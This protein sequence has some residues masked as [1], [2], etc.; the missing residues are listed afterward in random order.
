[1]KIG[2]INR[3]GDYPPTTNTSVHAYQITNRL[4]EKGCKIH[5]LEAYPH[6]EFKRFN[7]CE[8]L[9]FLSS[10]DILYIKMTGRLFWDSLSLLKLFKPSKLPLV[11]EMHSPAEFMGKSR[12]F[13][14]GEKRWQLLSK[15][16]DAA[17]CVSKEVSNYAKN[18]GLKDAYVVQNGSDPEMFS[19]EKRDPKIYSFLNHEDLKILWTGSLGY[20]WHGSDII[21]KVAKRFL[22]IN[23]RVK[24]ILIGKT[25]DANLPHEKNVIILNQIPYFSIPP[26]IASA[27]ICLCLYNSFDNQCSIGF[28]FSPL[29]LFDYMASAK[30]VIASAMGQIKEVIRD[31]ENGFITNNSV[32]DIVEKILFIIQNRKKA[33]ELGEAAR[34]DVINYYNWNRATVQILEVFKNVLVKYRK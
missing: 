31:G 20:W 25:N 33:A 6:P 22:N 18:I 14:Q 3:D 4:L 34:Q 11:W 24:F 16:A 19:P 21:Y 17:I 8:I 28:H 15:I 26:Y 27:D 1:M 13:I 10:I 12:F 32:D 30:P 2:Y 9:K 5:S 29:K 23:E 7:R